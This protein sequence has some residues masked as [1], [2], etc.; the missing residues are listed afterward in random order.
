MLCLRGKEEGMETD[1]A[2]RMENMAILYHSIIGHKMVQNEWAS[3]R[4]HTKKEAQTFKNIQAECEEIFS[5]A[6]TFPG[7]AEG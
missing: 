1:F 3:G 2:S 5:E 7:V 6:A 4:K